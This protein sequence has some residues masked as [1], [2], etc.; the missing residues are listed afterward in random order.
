MTTWVLIIVIYTQSPAARPA[1]H[2]AGITSV[3]GYASHNDCAEAGDYI[4][5]SPE[6]MTAMCIPGPSR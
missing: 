3:P 1:G 6:F 5:G 4:K 2:P